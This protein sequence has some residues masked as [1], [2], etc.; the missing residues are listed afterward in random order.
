MEKLLKTLIRFLYTV[1]NIIYFL[2]P[3]IALDKPS[4]KPT[5]YSFL[6]FNEERELLK[7]YMNKSNVYLEFGSGGSTF[8]ALKSPIKKV[9]S[10]ES[11]LSWTERMKSWAFIKK[12]IEQER[13]DL[14]YIN[15]GETTLFSYPDNIEHKEK[16]P[17][18]S[19]ILNKNTINKNVDTVLVDG[20]FRVACVLNTILNCSAGV[21]IIIHDFWNR[22]HYHVVLKYLDT[23][24]KTHTLGVF[25]I[26]QNINIDEIKCLYE[27]YKYI[28]D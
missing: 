6:N 14:I 1:Q 10:I 13:L 15:I 12:S 3:L 18:Y 25:K 22:K 5:R 21:I 19:N 23:I 28:P 24:E 2:N 8:E 9:F 7:K 16:F 11:S 4:K 17:D 27:E 20:R 26:K